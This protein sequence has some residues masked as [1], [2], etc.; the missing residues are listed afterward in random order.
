MRIG[1]IGAGRMGTPM[2]ARLTQAGHGVRVLTRT[3]EKRAA[4]AERGSEPVSS[5]AEAAE[6]ADAVVICVFTDEQVRQ[7]CLDSPLLSTLPPGAVVAVHTTGS[8]HIAETVAAQAKPYQ[9]QVVDAAVSG[10]PHD[11]AA[12]R[13]TVFLGGTVA[14]AARAR[15]VLEAYADPLLHV[16][17]LGTGQ[18]VKLINNA[19]FAANIGL[20]AEAVRL[21]SQI[22]VDETTLLAALP[23][24]SSAS[25]ALISVAAK[26]SITAFAASVG[27]FLGKDI[28]VARALAGELNANLGSLAPAIDAALGKE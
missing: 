10:G 17:P 25:R 2:V 18:R 23:H 20:V 11:I 16:G 9:V 26:G 6:G 21:A 22:G 15:P 1:F 14:A 8:P 27:E 5:V 4:L 3:P 19:L 28:A 7:V 24:A 12:G 13:L